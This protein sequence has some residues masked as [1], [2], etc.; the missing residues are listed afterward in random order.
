MGPRESELQNMQRSMPNRQMSPS[1]KPAEANAAE[2]SVQPLLVEEDPSDSQSLSLPGHR[3]N[4]ALTNAGLYARQQR[5]SIRKRQPSLVPHTFQRQRRQFRRGHAQIQAQQLTKQLTQRLMRP[6]KI[7]AQ[8]AQTL[9]LSPLNKLDPRGPQQASKRYSTQSPLKRRLRTK[10]LSQVQPLSTQTQ[11]SRPAQWQN[12]ASPQSSVEIGK[13]GRS[14]RQNGRGN[15]ITQNKRFMHQTQQQHRTGLPKAHSVGVDQALDSQF[16]DGD[17][18]FLVDAVTKGSPQA[19]VKRSTQTFKRAFEDQGTDE[20][21]KNLD[22]EDQ[23][24]NVSVATTEEANIANAN[25]QTKRLEAEV[26][27]PVTRL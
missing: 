7:V 21:L 18:D 17:A 22:R 26:F 6:V 2:A 1:Y 3:P 13:R 16:G 25:A 11:N 8:R 27:H 12:S 4:A 10:R 23:F 14:R 19:H 9:S 20:A 15:R 5:Q 24:D